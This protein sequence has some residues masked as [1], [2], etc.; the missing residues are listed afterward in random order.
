MKGIK[1][2]SL[3]VVAALLLAGCATAQKTSMEGRKVKCPACGCE[4]NL[5]SEA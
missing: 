1:A 4:F 2:L 5:P 3:L